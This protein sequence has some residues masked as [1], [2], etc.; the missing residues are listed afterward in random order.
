MDLTLSAYRIRQTNIITRDPGNPNIAIQGGTQ[1]SRGV[2]MAVSASVTRQFRLDANVAVLDAQYD[3]LLE[4]GGADRSGNTPP[5]MPDTVVNLFASYQFNA[6]PVKL[7]AGMRRTSDIFG[8]TANTVSMDGYTV[9][10]AS[11]SYMFGSGDLTLRARNLTDERYIE[12]GGA[13]AVY[14][15]APRTIDLTLRTSF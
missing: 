6:L 2:D 14:I 9:S 8:N 11:I 1:T 13:N 4:A 5:N 15:A 3:E 7:T 10:D 12:R